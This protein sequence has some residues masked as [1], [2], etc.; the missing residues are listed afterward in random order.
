MTMTATQTAAEVSKAMRKEEYMKR[1]ASLTGLRDYERSIRPENLAED[2]VLT[3]VPFKREPLRRFPP[4]K[5]WP[6][7]SNRPAP[8]SVDVPFAV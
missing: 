4:P 6:R 3:S 8:A 7:A 1:L 5:N 2:G